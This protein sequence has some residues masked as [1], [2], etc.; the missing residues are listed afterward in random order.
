MSSSSDASAAGTTDGIRLA[1]RLGDANGD[2]YLDLVLTAAEPERNLILAGD[3]SSRFTAGS[4]PS[5]L[6]YSAVFDDFD[7]DGFPDLALTDEATQDVSLLFGDATSGFVVPG[8]FATAFGG[9]SAADTTEASSAEPTA[10]VSPE[11]AAPSGQ[12]LM[13]GS[14]DLN[15]D[16]ADDLLLT[17]PV[18]GAASAFLRQEDGTFATEPDA[19]GATYTAA[20][21]EFDGDG[22]VDLALSDQGTGVVAFL[23]GDG[24][25]GFSP[26]SS[27]VS[28]A[29]EDWLAARFEDL[30]A[31]GIQDLLLSNVS[32]DASLAFMGDADG[33]YVS[34]PDADGQVYSANFGDLDGD[35]LIDLALA[36]DAT[37]SVA[38]LLGDG[39]GGFGLVSHEPAAPAVIDV[40][41]VTAQV[42]DLDADGVADLAL[43][44]VATGVTAQF[45]GVEDRIF[46][47]TQDG[48]SYRAEMIDINENGV[49][50]LIMSD[51]LTG[52]MSLLLGDGT[53]TFTPI[54]HLIVAP[55]GQMV[56]QPLG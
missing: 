47:L 54:G 10:E 7:G 34:G 11:P 6:D 40:G 42:L 2:G 36:Q 20:L 19:D 18:T 5:E 13:A 52:T 28:S 43:T 26:L 45:A 25:G 9:T 31:D 46:G 3:G 8:S 21:I 22:L 39:E 1:A 35:G 33:N 49:Y 37:G 23:L 48:V 17:D 44:D 16:G 29:P 55:S 27:F 12:F 24:A 32:S 51:T 50:D 4:S 53:G 30:D 15:A 56:L 38:L 14:V 41:T